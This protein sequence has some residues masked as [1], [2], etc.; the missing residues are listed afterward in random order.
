ME[1]H[2]H[3]DEIAPVELDGDG[4]VVCG[5]GARAV[6][7]HHPCGEP[8]RLNAEFPEEPR[9]QAVEFETEAAAL[10]LHD[11]LEKGRQ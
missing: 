7:A 11:F 1:F 8:V 4:V 6:L 10:A 5:R 3:V 2:A 9:E